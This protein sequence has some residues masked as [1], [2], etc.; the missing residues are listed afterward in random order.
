[1]S[2]PIQKAIKEY[3]ADKIDALIPG[4]VKPLFARASLLQSKWENRA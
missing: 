1:M 2:D 4:G 3:Y